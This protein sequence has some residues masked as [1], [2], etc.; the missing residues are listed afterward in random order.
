VRG[1]TGNND[2]DVVASFDASVEGETAYTAFAV[3]YLTPD[4]EPADAGFDVLVA[5]GA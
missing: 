2:G 5:Q 3:G 1:D 4:D